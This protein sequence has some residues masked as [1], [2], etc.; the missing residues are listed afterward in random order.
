[1][2][3]ADAHH[4][5]CS[6]FR[7]P[8]LQRIIFILPGACIDQTVFQFFSNSEQTEL[9][10]LP[11]LPPRRLTGIWKIASASSLWKKALTVSTSQ[12]L[13]S[14]FFRYRTFACEELMPAT[15]PV[16]TIRENTQDS[17]LSSAAKTV[18]VSFQSSGICRHHV[19]FASRWSC[20]SI[21]LAW[22]SH[23]ITVHHHLCC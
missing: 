16:A 6:H 8:N 11:I 4:Y 5:F 20:F 22:I 7:H 14:E 15:K 21:A 18:L 19:W 2:T 12:Q 9:G 10:L 17:I 13:P 3:D 23:Q 1:M